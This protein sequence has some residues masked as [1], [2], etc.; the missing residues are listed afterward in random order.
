M[1]RMV[2]S[3]LAKSQWRP[4]AGGGG[5][6]LE[7]PAMWHEVCEVKLSLS[8]CECVITFEITHY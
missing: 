1:S 5:N 4:E 8:F 3:C 7:R 2:T 6:D